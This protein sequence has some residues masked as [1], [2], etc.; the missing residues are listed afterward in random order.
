METGRSHGQGQPPPLAA[1]KA[2]AAPLFSAKGTL[3]VRSGWS[4][5]KAFDALTSQVRLGGGSLRAL[6]HHKAG[7]R[8]QKPFFGGFFV[9]LFFRFRQL[10]CGSSVLGGFVGFSRAFFF[11][12]SFLLGNGN[13]DK[14]L[15]YGSDLCLRPPFLSGFCRACF[16]WQA[17]CIFFKN[18]HTIFFESVCSKCF[19]VELFCVFFAVFF[20]SHFF[21][22]VGLFCTGPNSQHT[23]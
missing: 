3:V 1:G 4:R 18:F 20:P 7:R 5:S 13:R 11:L 16:F 17:Y 15:H 21:V 12:A 2:P 6:G 23:M 22:H 19:E 8:T 9:L 10:I 14:D